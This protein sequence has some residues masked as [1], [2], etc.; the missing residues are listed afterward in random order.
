[1]IKLLVFSLLLPFSLLHADHHGEKKEA[2]AEKWIPL[3][4]G[5]DLEGWT[6]KFSG[7]DLGL[8]YKDTFQVKEGLLTINYSQW[9]KFAGEF[10]RM[11][12]LRLSRPQSA[13]S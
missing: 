11:S 6:P 7:S 1:M 3:F 10:A 9:E 5:K 13:L 8:N 2:P 12:T 4:N